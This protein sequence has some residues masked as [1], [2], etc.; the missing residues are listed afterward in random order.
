MLH[1]RKKGYAMTL[2]KIGKFEALKVVNEFDRALIELFGIN[3]TDAR[4]T[5]YEALSS[6]EEARCARKAAELF[7]SQRGMPLLSANQS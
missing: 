1:R 5:R 2:N 3:M 7:G 6:I 4:I